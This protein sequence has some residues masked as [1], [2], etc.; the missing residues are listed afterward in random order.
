MKPTIRNRFATTIAVLACAATLGLVLAGC[1]QQTP[2]PTNSA[3][4]SPSSSSTPSTSPSATP[5]ASGVPSIPVTTACTAIFTA[6]QVYDF[7]PNYVATASYKPAPGTL[8]AQAAADQG[9]ACAWL[10]ETS[11]VKLEI[12]VARPGNLASLRSGA[13]GSSE[14]LG[15]SAV[16][17]FSTA[18]GVGR[19]QIFSGTYWI[20]ISSQD[21]S[22]TGDVDPI[23]KDVLGNLNGA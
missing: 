10:N 11:G 17:Y 22:G 8:Q 4:D 20:V 1:V 16:G 18:G 6:Q 9:R 19:M 23:A 7:N 15:G 14:Q 13:S 12:S 3:T 21:I 5:T 2:N